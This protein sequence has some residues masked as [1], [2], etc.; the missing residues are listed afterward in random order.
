[1]FE[2]VFSCPPKSGFNMGNAREKL[3]DFQL[4]QAFA[5]VK[6]IFIR[7]EQAP[8]RAV[9]HLDRLDLSHATF[10]GTRKTNVME[11]LPGDAFGFTFENN[12]VRYIVDFEHPGM[13]RDGVLFH[14]MAFN[15]SA[16]MQ[17]LTREESELALTVIE[18]ELTANDRNKYAAVLERLHQ[19]IPAPT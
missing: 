3:R 15:S 17:A 7:Q 9:F 10:Y 2:V 1:M 16:R 12:S 6:D 13:L 19:N 8:E 5:A 18:S 11:Y 14:K 4:K